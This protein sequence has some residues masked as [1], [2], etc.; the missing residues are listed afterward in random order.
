MEMSK[1]TVKVGEMF[2]VER[3]VCAST[4]TDYLLVLMEG[5]LA[6]VNSYLLPESPQL[7]GAP[8]KK[9][10]VFRS[11]RPGE[12]AIQ[13]GIYHASDPLH[14]LYE[15]VTPIQVVG[16]SADCGFQYGGWSDFRELNAE[17][18]ELFNKVM[19]RIMGVGYKPLQVATQLVAGMNYCFQCEAKSVTNP[20]QRY[21]VQ[22][23]IFAP[24]P[25][26]GEPYVTNIVRVLG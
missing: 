11:I 6:L 16:E 15:E 24:L 3:D 21:N 22:I 10:F 19:G 1:R 17:D 13:F 18:Q 4:G 14:I 7:E 9:S 12:A 5:G 25:G 26:R 2:T 23:T 20:P 8:A